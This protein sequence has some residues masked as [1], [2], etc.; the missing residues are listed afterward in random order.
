MVGHTMML[1]NIKE[2]LKRFSKKEITLKSMTSELHVNS[3]YDINTRYEPNN[4]LKNGSFM[5][6]L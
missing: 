2:F 4:D 1:H 6:T 3:M 5:S